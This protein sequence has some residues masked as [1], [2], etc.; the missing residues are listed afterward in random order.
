MQILN[1]IQILKVPDWILVSFIIS[2]IFFAVSFFTWLDDGGKGLG[3]FCII[4]VV[5]T[6]AFGISLFF[7]Q[8]TG[9]V[10]YEIR[11]SDETSLNEFYDKYEILDKYEYSNVYI[12][13]EKKP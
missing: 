2:C 4:T 11:V 1:T 5:A 9:E 13:K 8:P 7:P 12:V 6:L 10:K 3:I